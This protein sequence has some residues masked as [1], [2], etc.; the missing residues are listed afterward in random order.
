MEGH[1]G[2]SGG[3]RQQHRP[4][5]GHKAWTPRT[6]DGERHRRSLL[7]FAAHAE[8]RAHR[9]TAARSA[10]LY[11]AKF[12]N[13]AAGPFAVEAI[14]AHDPD[15]LVAPNKDRGKDA[16]MPKRHNHPPRL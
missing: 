5:L 2:R 3:P 16:G 13:D 4:G 10:N 14:A 6:V 11:E 8:E 1:H 7:D 12:P 15:L 9:A